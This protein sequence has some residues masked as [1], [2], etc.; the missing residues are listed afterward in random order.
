MYLITM[1]VRV[2]AL[3]LAIV[4]A[5]GWL[6]IV[7]IVLALVLPWVAVVVAN[8]GPKRQRQEQPSLYSGDK[9]RELN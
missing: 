4:L 7:A 2:V 8:A 5:S 3:I 6:R 9:P 1:G